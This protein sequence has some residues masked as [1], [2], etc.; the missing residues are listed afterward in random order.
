MLKQ[1]SIRQACWSKRGRA[2]HP[3]AAVTAQ[4]IADMQQL[5]AP[6]Q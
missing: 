1:W 6:Q 5:Q 4:V 2:G 3:E